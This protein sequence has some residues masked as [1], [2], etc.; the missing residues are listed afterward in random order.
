MIKHTDPYKKTFIFGCAFFLWLPA[1]I[2]GIPSLWAYTMMGHAFGETG[3][4]LPY[5]IASAL[6]ILVILFI[7]TKQWK[8]LH[9]FL[10]H[11][12]EV[13]VFEPLSND[14][15]KGWSGDR[16]MGLDVQHGVLV[17][18]APP[19][20]S[21]RT[22]FVPKDYIVM[23]FDMCSYKSAELLG[24]R[25]TIYTGKP[26]IPY[27]VIEHKNAPLMYEKLAAMRNRPYQN[28]SNLP[29]YIDYCAAR[30]A[31][32]RNLNLIQSRF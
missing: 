12:K 30:V 2:L 20:F 13:G 11:F 19:P 23:G 3:E 4:V 15:C 29:G 5:Y 17:Y 32:G 25:L 1:V 26:D 7:I 14:E 22:L 9:Y 6:S 8:Q 28:G 21:V 16:Y 24:R 31:A 27:V 10:N 18:I